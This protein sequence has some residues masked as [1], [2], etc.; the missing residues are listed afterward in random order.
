MPSRL[1]GVALHAVEL[2]PVRIREPS[3]VL[4]CDLVRGIGFSWRCRCGERG[5]VY[6]SWREARAE[7]MDHVRNLAVPVIAANEPAREEDA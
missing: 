2:Y 4:G 7:G 3:H 1:C 5:K 6:G